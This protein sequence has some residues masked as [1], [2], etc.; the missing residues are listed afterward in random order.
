MKNIGFK[1]TITLAIILL[2]TSCLLVASWISYRA[3]KQDTIHFVNVSSQSITH[4]EA[5]AISRWFNHKATA[6]SAIASQYQQGKLD[7]QFVNIARLAKQAN[8]LYSVF[9]GFEDGTSYASVS[10]DA[11]WH[12]GVADPSLYDPRPRGWYQLAKTNDTEQLTDIYTDMVT[13]QPV[14]SIV[15]NI[16]DGVLSG[17][18]GLEILDKTVKQIDFPGAVASIIDSKGKVLASSDA[19]F[20]VGKTL[21]DAGLN[22]LQ[23]DIVSNDSFSG[24]YQTS[25]NQ[26]LVFSEA[27]PLIGTQKWYLF[28]SVDEQIA[29]AGLNEALHDSMWISAVMLLV[30][31]GLVLAI[32]NW[33]YRPI[34][35][36][37]QMV[38][39]LSQGQADLTRRL[40]VTSHDDLGDIAGGINQFVANLQSLLKEI[41]F[42]TQEISGS[43][44]KLYQQTNANIDV[45]QQHVMETELV[46]TAVEE[47]SATALEVVKNTSQ[48]SNASLLASQQVNDTN[49]IVSDTKATVV[50]LIQD[51]EDTEVNISNVELDAISITKVLEVI[52][53]IADQTNLLALNAAI[54]AARAGDQGRGFAVVADEVRALAARTQVSTTEIE[55]TLSKLQQG[56]KIAVDAMQQTKKTCEQANEATIDVSENLEKV[57]LSITQ[58]N[59]LNTQIATAAEE[60]NAV[61][62]DVS[63]NM[64]AI[65]DMVAV[66]DDNGKSTELEAHKLTAAN[67]KLIEVVNKFTIE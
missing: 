19:R 1:Q 53:A 63:R 46:V 54:E 58:V 49:N 12:D 9:W 29:Y 47:M 60:Q 18:I 25:G 30:S 11:I 64:N 33:L 24:E 48:A 10:D 56:I 62:E 59:D 34:L 31:I 14:I 21:A 8:E 5:G 6:V 35:H 37:K 39:A 66:L 42:G 2:V 52:G 41:S 40:P 17:D 61:S 27:I 20:E 4:Y 32:L 13:N 3:L 57:V 15:T 44:G 43:I 22:E 28:I 36:L 50:R 16:G 45:L 26:Q 55:Q 23:R 51:V 38:V 7:K 65:R 67:D